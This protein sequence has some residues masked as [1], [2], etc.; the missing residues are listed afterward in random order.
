MIRKI[1]EKMSKIPGI[2]RVI[3]KTF[4]YDVINQLLEKVSPNGISKYEI[5]KLLNKKDPI[6]LEIG[7]H[8]GADT[9]SFLQIIEKAKLYC[10]E[11]NPKATLKFKERI[12][13]LK[14]RKKNINCSLFE[15]AISDKNGQ[16][17]FYITAEEKYSAQSTLKKPKSILRDSQNLWKDGETIIVKTEKLD[18]W[19]KKKNIK[20][21][22]FI[23]ADTEGS[24]RALITGGSKT[25][26]EKTRYFYTEFNNNEIFE[27]QPNLSEILKLLP[28]FKLLKI[29]G[30]NI[31]LKNIKIEK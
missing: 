12:K 17:E 9:I 23:W 14:K 29:Y 30:N 6:L 31:L 7:A 22:D 26:N 8:D 11:P 3:K 28:N 19:V 24:E 10:F 16:A 1:T 21:I 25:L 4:V 18:D 13:E 15:I 2:K 20:Q 27:N 5:K